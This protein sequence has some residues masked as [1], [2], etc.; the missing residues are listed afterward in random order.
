MSLSSSTVC[1]YLRI[2]RIILSHHE[3]IYTSWGDRKT[4]SREELSLLIVSDLH[5]RA[6]TQ[7]FYYGSRGTDDVR[8][9]G[10]KWNA[11][12]RIIAGLRAR[13]TP[14]MYCVEKVWISL[15]GHQMKRARTRLGENAFATPR[16]RF[17][18]RRNFGLSRVH[19]YTL[20]Y[21]RRAH[22]KESKIYRRLGWHVVFVHERRVLIRTRK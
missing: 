14:G 5:A 7:R 9:M 17:I 20:R 3:W 8:K 1:H 4:C 15:Q 12:C 10:H 11:H 6:Q 13:H 22:K 18:C 16:M 19:T 21:T 2:P